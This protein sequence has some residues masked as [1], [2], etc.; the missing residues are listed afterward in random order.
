MGRPRRPRHRAP[1]VSERDVVFVQ[2]VANVLATAIER[3]DDER[4]LRQ[5]RERLAAL[6]NLDAAVREITGAA[7][8]QSTREEVETLVCEHLAGVGSDEFA[9]IAEVDP[10]T[11]EIE[12]HQEAGVGGYI[13]SIPLSTDPDDPAGRGPVGR[14]VRSREL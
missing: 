3:R 6:D 5:Q 2:S 10:A 7:I 13:D 4:R 11:G 9:W 1:G 8:G 12:A 14:A